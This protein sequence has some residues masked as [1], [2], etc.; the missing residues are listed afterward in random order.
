MAVVSYRRHCVGR[1]LRQ[2]G[3]ALLQARDPL[4]CNDCADPALQCGTCA[5]MSLYC[6]GRSM[7]LCGGGGGARRNVAVP[8][9]QHM[10]ASLGQEQPRVL[11]EGGAAQHVG[12]A[13]ERL[14]FF[15][16]VRCV[17]HLGRVGAGAGVKVG[18]RVR[19]GISVR[20]GMW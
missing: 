4:Y 19:V 5:V 9:P 18:V 17:A 1:A 13:A 10:R 8:A 6:D 20:V 16:G 14:S 3:R 15:P 11:A 7:S 2:S 12:H